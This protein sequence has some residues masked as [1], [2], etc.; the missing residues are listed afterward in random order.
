MAVIRKGMGSRMKILIIRHGDPDYAHD[1][2]TERGRMEAACLA[3][4]LAKMDIKE[5]YVSPLGRARETASYTCLLY[6]SPSPRD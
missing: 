1:S 4:R 6:T 5:F 3:E 2:L